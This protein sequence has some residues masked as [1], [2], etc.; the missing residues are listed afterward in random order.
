M[1][2]A[3]HTESQPGDTYIDDD[4]HYQ[5]SVVHGVIVALPM[6]EHEKHPEWWWW[7]WWADNAPEN[8]DF[9]RVLNPVERVF[10]QKCAFLDDA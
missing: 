2:C 6:P 4:L 5:M 1:W 3:A 10:D 9:W 7:W 8:A